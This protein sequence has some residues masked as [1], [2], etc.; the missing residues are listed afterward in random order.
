T[1][2]SGS[3]DIIID[4]VNGLMVEPGQP[5]EMAQALRRI[6]EDGEFAQQLAQE[7]R[8]TTL[9][10]YQITTVVERCLDLYRRLLNQHEQENQTT[11]PF[12][13]SCA[14]CF[15]RSNNNPLRPTPNKQRRI[16]PPG[17][18]PEG[19]MRRVVEENMVRVDSWFPG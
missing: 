7:A 18:K 17:S 14:K 2:V 19:E 9:R 11:K 3:E 10:D 13:L 12:A 8:A 15:E 6:I 4:G 16:S 1:R 5:A